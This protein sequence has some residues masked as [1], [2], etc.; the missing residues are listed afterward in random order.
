[1]YAVAIDEQ[2]RPWVGFGDQG[3]SVLNDDGSWTTYTYLHY[4][5]GPYADTV[6]SIVI[7]DRGRVWI[8]ANGGL[9]VLDTDGTWTAYTTDNSGLPGSWVEALAVDDQGRIWVGIDSMDGSGLGVF[10]QEDQ[11]A[12]NHVKLADAYPN[13]GPLL[14]VLDVVTFALLAIAVIPPDTARAK[15]IRAFAT[16][17]AGWFAVNTALSW[18][19]LANASANP[20]GWGLLV[21]FFLLPALGFA[22][23]GVSIGLS[24]VRRTRW[25][26][27]GTLA[28]LVA[29]IMVF[30][31]QHAGLPDSYIILFSA[32]AIPFYVLRLFG[33]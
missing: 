25:Q 30:L 4:G 2:D 12:A 14:I 7:D 9:S 24:L 15:R 11:P 3:I 1:V 29:N 6:Q 32:P 27:V 20:E 28:A 33:E 17:F 31:F 10:A 23:A 13:A 8:G 19:L 5:L 26:G 18:A 22:N 16:G 21:I